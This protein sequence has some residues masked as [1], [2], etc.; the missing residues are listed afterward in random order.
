MKKT[1]IHGAIVNKFCIKHIPTG[2]VLLESLD[3]NFDNTSPAVF[4]TETDAEIYLTLQEVIPDE[5]KDI[6]ICNTNI[7]FFNNGGILVEEL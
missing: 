2:K 6:E 5:R 4:N 7:S 3:N 1:E